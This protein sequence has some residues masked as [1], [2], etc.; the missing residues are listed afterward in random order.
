M[1][2]RGGGGYGAIEV[3]GAMGHRGDGGYGAIEVVGAMVVGAMGAVV[4]T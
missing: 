3:V 1:G 2:H 4:L